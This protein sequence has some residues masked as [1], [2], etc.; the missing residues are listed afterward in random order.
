MTTATA[1]TKANLSDLEKDNF[2]DKVLTVEPAPVQT[3]KGQPG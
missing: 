1:L 3:S 2:V